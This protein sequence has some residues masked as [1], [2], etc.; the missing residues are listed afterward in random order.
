MKGKGENED[1]Q[2]LGRGGRKV[3]GGK[4]DRKSGWKE[5]KN[6]LEEGEEEEKEKGST[7][8]VEVNV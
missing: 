1:K 5:G 6:L 4:G 8:K 2:K 7:E 3:G